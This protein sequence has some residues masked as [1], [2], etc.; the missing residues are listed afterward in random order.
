MMV[1][2]VRQLDW[3]MGCLDIR[4]DLIPGMS[5]GLFLDEVNK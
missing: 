1:N 5:R 3:A 2:F 4:S